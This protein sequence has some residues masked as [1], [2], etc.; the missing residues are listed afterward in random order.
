M[1]EKELTQIKTKL[2][3]VFKLV[4]N[5][6]D[7]ELKSHYSRYLCILVSGYIENYLKAL[8]KD[9]SKKCSSPSIQNYISS[10]FQ[11][12]TNLKDS[13]LQDILGSFSTDWK[14]R[15]LDLLTTEQKDAVDSVVTNRNHIAHGKS[16]GITLGRINDYYKDISRLMNNI[17]NNVIY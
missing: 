6:D 1:I 16:V 12:I 10:Q 7:D 4:E 2:D 14:Q 3:S 13:K 8:L 15:Y 5:I 9:Y 11:N 17:K